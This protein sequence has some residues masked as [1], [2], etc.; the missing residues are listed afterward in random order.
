MGQKIEKVIVDAKVFMPIQTVSGQVV[1]DMLI[2]YGFHEV[3]KFRVD[4][5]AE[6]CI[7]SVDYF[8]SYESKKKFFE[9]NK[10]L[11]HARSI[12]VINEEKELHF[13]FYWAL[14]SESEKIDL[15]PNY[16]ETH[17]EKK[18][19]AKQEKKEEKRAKKR[20]NKEEGNE[21]IP[22]EEEVT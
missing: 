9:E 7:A 11:R 16:S 17:Q 6:Y 3:A 14:F 5:A 1:A 15:W 12:S 18:M 22:Q 13:D 2:E 19:R 8:A 20:K 21:E 10:K 4:L